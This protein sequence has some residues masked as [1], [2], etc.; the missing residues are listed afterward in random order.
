M[1][2][3]KR[4]L[5]EGARRRIITCTDEEHLKVKELLAR[6]RK[7]LARPKSPPEA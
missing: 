6:L 2:G 3:R 5:P 1:R 7:R 4:T